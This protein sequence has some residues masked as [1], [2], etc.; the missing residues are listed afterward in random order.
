MILCIT[1]KPS[2]G[3]DI[4]DILA[5]STRRN[6]YFEGNGYCVTRAFGH[7][8]F[9]SKACR[10]HIRLEAVVAVV[11]AYDSSAFRNQAHRR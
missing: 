9:A 10:L 8:C 5:T 1:E 11:A 7:L 2:V 6:G 3:K 4:A